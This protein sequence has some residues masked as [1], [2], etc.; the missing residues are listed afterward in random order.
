MA[1]TQDRQVAAEHLIALLAPLQTG[2]HDKNT[3]AYGTPVAEAS[4]LAAMQRVVS[5]LHLDGRLYSALHDGKPRFPLGGGAYAFEN[6]IVGPLLT[7]LAHDEDVST[8][9]PMKDNSHPNTPDALPSPDSSTGLDLDAQNG[10]SMFSAEGSRVDVPL[11][12][13]VVHAGAQPNNSPHLGTL[14]V[15]CYAFLLAKGLRDRLHGLGCATIDVVVEITFVDTAP[16]LS[17]VSEVEGVSYQRSYRDVPGALATYI[18]DYYHALN[19]MSQWSGIPFQTKYQSDFFSHPELPGLLAWMT[20]HRQRLAPQ[21]SPKYHALALRA[22]CPV[23]GC[24]MAEKHGRL[25]VYPPGQILFRCP[26]H[27]VHGVDLAQPAEVARLEAN[28][29]ARNLLR[30]LTHMLDETT[31]HVRVTGADYAGTYQ[32]TCLYRPLAVWAQTMRRAAGRTPHILYAPLVVDWSGAKLSKS[33][34]KREGGYGAMKA[35][36]MEALC[37]YA[38][39]R[40]EYGED[41][42]RRLWEEVERW[43]AEPHKLFRASYSI[44]YFKGILG[45]N[46]WSGGCGN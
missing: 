28:T 20:E 25:N 3:A 2:S 36:G 37:S 39:L 22:A 16:V 27:G 29:P 35:L 19:S 31:H 43:F 11:R 4:I 12:P 42:L 14:S 45:G 46:R 33:L 17:N 6:D 44:E 10:G 23:P 18:D 13:I 1:D 24:G 30:S 38:K 32:E 5:S 41:G 21:L 40:S 8:T 15:F 7:A 9:L 26:R 34:Y